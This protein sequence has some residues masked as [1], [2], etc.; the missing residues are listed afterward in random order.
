MKYGKVKAKYFFMSVSFTVREWYCSILPV[1]VSL[2]SF[3]HACFANLP[4]KE[5]ITLKYISGKESNVS[6]V[7]Y[8]P[9]QI[10]T[11]TTTA[12]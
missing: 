11:T 3:R 12:L 8:W 5:H 6:K 2:L 7:S 4:K 9:M 1:R 10:V